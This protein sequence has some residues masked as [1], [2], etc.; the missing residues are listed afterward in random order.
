LIR[1]GIVG[2]DN[3]HA[4]AFAKL[5][6]TT[7]AGG[8]RGAQVTAIYGEQEARTAEV[9]AQGQIPKIVARPEEMI[10]CIDGV[11]IVLRHG[12][13]HAQYALPFL[14]AG[15]PVWVDKPLALTLEDASRMIDAANRH[16][17]PMSSFSTLRYAGHTQ[18]FLRKMRPHGTL[19]TGAIMGAN[20]GAGAS[21][22]AYGGLPFYGIHVVELL[23][24]IFG[25]GVRDVQTV[26][27][28]THV[29]ATV[30]YHDERIVNLQ[31]LGDVEPA[32][33]VTA[34]AAGGSG[35]FQVDTKD[36]YQRGL[37]VILKMMKTGQRPLTDDQLL[38]TVR[39]MEMITQ[40]AASTV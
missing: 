30:C 37:Q 33:H 40:G 4:I 25:Y 34:Y 16:G 35:H 15:V 11:L 23:A 19:V 13:E 6:N 12:G 21:P 9:A 22:D 36:C 24:E 3:F 29:Q 38:E 20:H 28:H 18:R 7:A 31:F 2:S 27:H 8:V 14:E 26:K 10:G 17:A 5:C 39:V 1:L 32:W